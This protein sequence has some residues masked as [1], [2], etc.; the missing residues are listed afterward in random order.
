MKEFFIDQHTTH[1]IM[2]SERMSEIKEI[3]GFAEFCS[4][5]PS[6]FIFSM[7]NEFILIK[8]YNCQCMYGKITFK[9][10]IIKSFLISNYA[11]EISDVEKSIELN[12]LF[13]EKKD[14]N[15]HPKFIQQINLLYHDNAKK[16]YV[17]TTTTKKNTNTIFNQILFDSNYNTAKEFLEEKYPFLKEELNSLYATITDYNEL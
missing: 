8:H 9:E 4:M 10:N 11:D 3:S 6:Y 14:N 16:Y 13:K 12:T 17:I 7:F 1:C 5:N 15:Y 2:G